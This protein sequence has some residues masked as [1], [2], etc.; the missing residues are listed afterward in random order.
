LDS[1]VKFNALTIIYNKLITFTRAW[2]PAAG[3]NGQWY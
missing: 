1:Y 2:G 3:S